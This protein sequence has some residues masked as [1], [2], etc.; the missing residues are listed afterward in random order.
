MA[1]LLWSEKHKFLSLFSKGE[2]KYLS[3]LGYIGQLAIFMFSDEKDPKS[4]SNHR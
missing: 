3:D 2:L 4:D 1:D